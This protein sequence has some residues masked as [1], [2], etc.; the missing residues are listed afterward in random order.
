MVLLVVHSPKSATQNPSSIPT[1]VPI[2]QL[3]SLQPAQ[4]KE[5]DPPSLPHSPSSLPTSLQGSNA[6][7]WLEISQLGIPRTLN[8]S[9]SAHS[10]LLKALEPFP[11]QEMSLTGIH[12]SFQAYNLIFSIKRSTTM[13]VLKNNMVGALFLALGPPLAPPKKHEKLTQEFK[14][15]S[16]ASFTHTFPKKW[17][18]STHA[19]IN[20]VS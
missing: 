16:H 14:F 11:Q 9:K 4:P 3:S 13:D 15:S 2:H 8:C 1:A 12:P 7:G 17:L 20:W 18:Y 19:I 6:L 5:R 10:S